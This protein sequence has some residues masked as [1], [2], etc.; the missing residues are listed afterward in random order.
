MIKLLLWAG[1]VY[2]LYRALKNSIRS[3]SGPV[4]SDSF[5]R[6]PEQV[7]DLMI[8]DPYCEVYFPRKDG[9]HLRFKGQDL[10]FCSPACRDNYLKEHSDDSA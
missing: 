6:T 9:H 5:P 2:L 8:Q 10:Y 7:D 1:I 3:G 4:G